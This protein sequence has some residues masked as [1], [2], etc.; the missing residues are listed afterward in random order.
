M[1]WAQ[2]WPKPATISWWLDSPSK[3]RTI[4][5]VMGGR[6]GEF[7]RSRNFF[8]LSNS[9]YEFFLRHCMNIFS[10]N[11]RAS[12]FFHLIFPCANI[13]FV[14]RPPLHKFSNG[15]S[16]SIACNGFFG[17]TSRREWFY[18]KVCWK[19][20]LPNI[21][22]Q[23]TFLFRSC[24]ERYLLSWIMRIKGSAFIVRL[25]ILIAT[26]RPH[27]TGLHQAMIKNLQC[28]VET[29]RSISKWQSWDKQ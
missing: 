10:V 18:R 4:R 20:Y 23:H 17:D 19:K 6:G 2:N 3:G 11:W 28:A 14:L 24:H 9:L 12:F 15:P 21:F 29:S 16:L 26:F 27:I 25:T 1:T 8:S 13:F 5:K 7:S 22:F